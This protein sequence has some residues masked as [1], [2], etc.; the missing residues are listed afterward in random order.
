MAANAKD[1]R[2]EKTRRSLWQA[3]FA[4]I[5]EQGYDATSVQ[6]ILNRAGVGRATF[7][8]HFRNKEDLLRCGMKAMSDG[9]TTE[10]NTAPLRSGE[11][12]AFTL[13]I[14]RHMDEHHRRYRAFLRMRKSLVLEH[15]LRSVLGQLVRQDLARRCRAVGKSEL[16]ELATAYTVSS[17]LAL[18]RW[19][20]D[21]NQGKMSPEE[22]NAIFRQLTL[23]GLD[24]MLGA[25]H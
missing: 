6:D 4:L 13:A 8:A 22:L 5:G 3:L 1:R 7:Y 12:L 9:F 21:R 18:V 23:P 2:I 17:F 14:L 24:A 20:V 10:W 16:S 19:W 11:P 15:H 25:A